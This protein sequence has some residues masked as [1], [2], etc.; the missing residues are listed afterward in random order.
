[1]SG[2]VPNVKP[3]VSMRKRRVECKKNRA[4]GGKE[5]HRATWVPGGADDD[6]RKDSAQRHSRNERG[7]RAAPLHSRRMKKQWALLFTSSKVKHLA[8]ARLC[9]PA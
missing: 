9:S 4:V 5:W 1:M 7:C 2:T 8:R 3:Q 6:A